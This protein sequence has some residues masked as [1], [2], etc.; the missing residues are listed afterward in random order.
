MNILSNVQ[1][2]AA[3]RRFPSVGENT[4]PTVSNKRENIHCIEQRSGSVLSVAPMRP[5][6]L[7]IAQVASI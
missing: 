2:E 4:S 1:V 7:F 6:V 3:M 5:I